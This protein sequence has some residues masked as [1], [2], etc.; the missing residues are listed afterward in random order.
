[1][2]IAA[3]AAVARGLL[4]AYSVAI[5]ALCALFAATLA[6]I[7]ALTGVD[8]ALRY[9]GFGSL[10]W[11]AE[12]FEYTLYAGTFVAA[13][14]ALRQGAHIRIDVLV[15]ALGERMAAAL[16]IVADVFGLLLSVMLAIYGVRA[17]VEAHLNNMVQ[18]KTWYVPESILLSAVAIGGFFLVI[19]FVLRLLRV[20]GVLA[21]QVPGTS[22]D[23]L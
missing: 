2:T 6:V 7:I 18:Y 8:V 3:R 1:L 15:L 14:W 22:R 16:E 20:K 11:L 12:L 21:K 19:E 9:W 4:T 17:V 13:P 5:R 10:P 23:T